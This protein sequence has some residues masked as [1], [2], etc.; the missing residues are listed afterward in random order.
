MEVI[1]MCVNHG[2]M[3]L[4]CLKT[5]RKKI[6]NV[7]KKCVKPQE[8]VYIDIL[9]WH[10]RSVSQRYSQILSPSHTCQMFIQD[11]HISSR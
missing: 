10:F 8:I 9:H 4:V 11:M 7:E 6:E 2:L 5:S 1:E 3:M